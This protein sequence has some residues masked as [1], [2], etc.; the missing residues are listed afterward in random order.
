[1]RILFKEGDHGATHI[2]VAEIT[3]LRHQDMKTSEGFVTGGCNSFA[4]TASG[5]ISPQFL[6]MSAN[7][8][9][10]S[11]CSSDGVT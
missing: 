3:T 8:S 7:R 11:C 5:N 1:M 2:C 10:R 4:E 9:V 6:K